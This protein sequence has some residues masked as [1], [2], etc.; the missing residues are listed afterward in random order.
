VNDSTSERGPSTSVTTPAE[1][2]VAAEHPATLRASMTMNKSFSVEADLMG[3]TA[4][5]VGIDS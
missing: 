1:V 4:V 3:A 5:S 2:P